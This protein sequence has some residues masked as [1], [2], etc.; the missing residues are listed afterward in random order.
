M[1]KTQNTLH[2]EAKT[3]VH[4]SELFYF[5]NAFLMNNTHL[6]TLL[7]SR[8]LYEDYHQLGIPCRSTFMNSYTYTTL[9]RPSKVGSNNQLRAALPTIVDSLFHAI[10]CSRIF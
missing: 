3:C 1:L 9:Q 4:G 10:E 8:K 7:K 2:T 6:K 5:Y